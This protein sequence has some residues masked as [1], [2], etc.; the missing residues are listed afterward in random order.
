MLG[1]LGV[2][3]LLVGFIW[4]WN[5]GWDSITCFGLAIAGWICID[6]QIAFD[7]LI[8]KLADQTGEKQKLDD[9][10]PSHSGSKT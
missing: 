3:A 2:V 7:D 8:D 1:F 10:V 6:H 4:S 9:D 5:I